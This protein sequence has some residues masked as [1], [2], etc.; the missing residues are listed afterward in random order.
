M[1]EIAFSRCVDIT[2][3]MA[4]DVIKACNER[5]IDC[6]VAPYEAD[7]QLAFL[8][9]T[10]G[11]A[12]LVISEDS[13]LTLFGCDQILFKLDAHGNGL[14]YERTKLPHCLGQRKDHP[15]KKTHTY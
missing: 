2:Q 13:D 9:T 4:R 14:L 1:Y 15:R 3:E 12:D 6:I 8:A 10:G 7:A 5:N 11:Y